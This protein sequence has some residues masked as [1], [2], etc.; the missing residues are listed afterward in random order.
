MTTRKI[1]ILL[2]LPTLAGLFALGVCAP[3]L[4]RAQ[5]KSADWQINTDAKD[6]RSYSGCPKTAE[7][8]ELGKSEAAL[9]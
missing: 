7:H 9:G 5:E 4:S 1:L 8:A 6:Q 2:V 3:T